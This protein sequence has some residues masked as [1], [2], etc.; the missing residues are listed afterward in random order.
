MLEPL[1]GFNKPLGREVGPKVVGVI[2]LG[3][4]RLPKHEVADARF[5]T[6][7][8]EQIHFGGVGCAQVFC[9]RFFGQILQALARM[10]LLPGLR[11][12]DHVPATTIVGA[13]REGDGLVVGRCGFGAGN[14]F[15]QHRGKARFVSNHLEADTVFVHGVDLFLQIG[16]EQVHEAGDFF[17]GTF[18]VF[19]AE[20][21]QAQVGNAHFGAAFDDVSHPLGARSMAQGRW[22]QALFGPA[23]IAI[24]DDGYVL[25]QG[26]VGKVR[27]QRLGFCSE[28]FKILVALPDA[29]ADALDRHALLAL[30]L[31]GT[32]YL[33]ASLRGAQRRGNPVSRP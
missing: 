1:D 23:P 3:I 7:A 13:H 15:L 17:F 18:P 27:G 25:R 9:Q 11:G 4:G 14:E 33:L 5:A 31:E 32:W 12:L 19:G 16:H 26:V 22:H 20:G 30:T 2:E 28:W 21:E 8:N 29:G 6:G 10:G 24:H